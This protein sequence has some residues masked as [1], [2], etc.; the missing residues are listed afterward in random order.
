MMTAT[1]PVA[2]DYLRRFE[3]AAR[4]LPARQR[5]EL[6]AEIRSHVST[7]LAPDSTE[8]DVHSLLDELGTPEAI[9]AAAQPDLPTARR[10][11]RETLALVLM[12]FG[13]IPILGWIV[14]V[15]LMLS[16]TLWSGR[17]KLLGI[18]VWPGGLGSVVLLGG[19]VSVASGAPC[20]TE[21]N[22]Q[23]TPTQG[24]LTATAPDPCAETHTS[25]PVTGVALIVL[26]VLA[27]LAV[28]GYLYQAA[29]RRS[30]QAQP[31]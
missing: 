8:A 17:Q 11:L 18:L 15:A 2:E 13:F 30:L 6:V 3:R 22:P 4:A 29:G 1:H 26:I 16:S 23:V 9:V 7:G 25:W 10:G 5:Q 21:V 14:G 12:V 24:Y 19:F 20:G 31:A 27:Q 28:A